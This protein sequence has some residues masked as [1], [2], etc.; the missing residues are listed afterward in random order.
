MPSIA[1]IEFSPRE[2]CKKLRLIQVNI[3][4]YKQSKKIPGLSTR[5]Q[6][7]FA[8]ALPGCALPRFSHRLFLDG[9]DAPDVSV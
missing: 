3:S 4:E 2:H 7:R 5:P 6:I 8:N 1:A 9:R